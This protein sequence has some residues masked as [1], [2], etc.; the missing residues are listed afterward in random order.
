MQI[1]LLSDDYLSPTTTYSRILIDRRR[2][3]PAL[4]QAEGK[5]WL[6]SSDCTGWSPNPAS[7]AVADHPLGPWTEYSNPCTGPGADTTFGAQST[8]VLPLA[9][10]KNHFIFMA[11]RWNK[12]DLENSTYL[13]LPLTFTNGKPVITGP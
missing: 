11:D 3:G 8:F 9:G 1:C 12:L 7:Y 13:W 2:E 5:Y 4:F 6:I 10:Q